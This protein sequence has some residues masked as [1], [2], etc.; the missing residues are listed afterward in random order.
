LMGIMG[1]EYGQFSS[2]NTLNQRQRRLND[3]I[4]FTPQG[5]LTTNAVIKSS[6][7]IQFKTNVYGG[8]LYTGQL[9][10]IESEIIGGKKPVAI[11]GFYSN[12]SDKQESAS[13]EA[14]RLPRKMLTPYYII[15]SDIISDAQYNSDGKTL[16]IVYVVN[17][18]NGFGDFF[19]QNT[20]ETNFTVTKAKTITEITTSIHNPDMSIAPTNEGSGIIYKIIKNN[21]ADMNVAEE[22]LNK[23]KKK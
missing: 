11:H 14:Q 5:S 17:K 15:R 13:I 3:E 12:V 9:P 22:I 23:N 7:V 8:E 1:F 21:N 6:D 20:T 19:F 4:T 2:N 16:P 18:E 10:S